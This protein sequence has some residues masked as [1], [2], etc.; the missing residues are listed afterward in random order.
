[1]NLSP[2]NKLIVL[3]AVCLV[4]TVA[5]AALL[6]FPA[7]QRIGT[8]DAEIEGAVMES[9]SARLLLDQRRAVKE[10]AAVTSAQLVQLS[11]AI[12]E[13]PEMPSLIID[14]H[15]T[16]HEAG[17]VLRAVVPGQP[18]VTE[19]LPYVA[20]PLQVEVQGTWADTIEFLGRANRL[21]RQ[22]RINSI[23]CDIVPE[24]TPE[25][26][27]GTGLTYPPYYQVRTAI[28]ATAYTIP[29][30]SLVDTPTAEVPPPAE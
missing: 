7:I 24:P 15:D 26:L 30:S 16:A 6:V 29:A 5:L 8:L 23:A 1:M 3:V 4:A 10:R 28:I 12:P 22:L 27:A 13:T 20:F 11:V 18:A 17:V 19:G 21:T 2:R 14:L 25:E 9:D